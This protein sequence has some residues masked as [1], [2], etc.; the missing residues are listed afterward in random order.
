MV[1]KAVVQ[2]KLRASAKKGRPLQAS[3]FG[4]RIGDPHLHLKKGGSAIRAPFPIRRLGP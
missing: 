2:H 1:I 4:T 3:P